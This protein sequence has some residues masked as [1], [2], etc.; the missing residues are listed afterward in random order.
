MPTSHSRCQPLS[1]MLNSNV[2]RSYFCKNLLKSGRHRVGSTPA[3]LYSVLTRPAAE[4]VKFGAKVHEG[5]DW[6]QP[7]E[8]VEGVN[9]VLVSPRSAASRAIA[10]KSVGCM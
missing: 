3:L 10:F 5:G 7:F 6:H 9:S 4:F 1:C 2:R 8:Q